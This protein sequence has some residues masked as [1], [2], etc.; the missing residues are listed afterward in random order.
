MKYNQWINYIAVA[1]AFVLPL[2]RAG[3]SFFTALIILLWLLEGGY[4]NKLKMLLDNKVIIAMFI[5]FV[6]NFISLFWTDEILSTLEYI[7][8]YWY[9]LPILVLYTSIQKEFIPKILS[10]FIFGM[11]ISEIIAYGIF[12]EFWP[13]NEVTYE[14]PS[15]F[16]HHIEY[17]IFLAFAILVLLNRIFNEDAIKTKVMY[18]FFF[19]TMS[20]NL[21]LTAGRTGQLALLVGLF[22]LAMINFKNKLKAF[23]IFSLLSTALISV[24]FN[25]SATF[26]NRVLT[27]GDNLVSVVEDDNYCTSWGGR[28]GVYIVSKDMITHS[29]LLGLGITDNVTMFRSLIDTTYPKMKCI[30]WFMHMHNQYLEIFTQLGIVGLLLFLNMFYR[31]AQVKVMDKEY[32][33]IKYTYLTVLGVAFISEVLFHRAFSLVL[34]S[35]VIGLLLAQERTE[36]EVPNIK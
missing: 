26:K 29:P 19:V 34:F 6:F 1:Y 7:R 32:Y 12:F 15:P 36:N 18:I 2:S 20:G 30:Q 16:M 14:N 4:K 33:S 8:R 17:S 9:L 11:F 28:V 22:V 31:I 3:I 25:F 35:L 23:I 5:F 13:F 21:F 10:A 24:A 27:A